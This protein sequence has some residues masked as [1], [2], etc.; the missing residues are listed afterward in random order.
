LQIG[1][2][3]GALRHVDRCDT[4][5]RAVLSTVRGGGGGGKGREEDALS[6]S[7]SLSLS[8]GLSLILTVLG[9]LQE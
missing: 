1:K 4:I 5:V 6:L 3:H 9:R 8:L 7:L 2:S